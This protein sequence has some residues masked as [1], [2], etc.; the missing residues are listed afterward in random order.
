[1]GRNY[2]IYGSVSGTAPGTPLPGGKKSLPIN[3]DQFTNI[4]ADLNYPDSV[5]FVNFYGLLDAGGNATASFK[6]QRLVP[7][8]MGL[9]LSFAYPLEGPPWDFVSN[10]LNIEVVP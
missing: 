1:V 6:T 3:W 4:V 10:P 8:M 2:L 9:T 7:E 5:V